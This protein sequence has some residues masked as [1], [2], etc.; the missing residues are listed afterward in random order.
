MICLLI[1]ETVAGRATGI[2]WNAAWVILIE[3]LKWSAQSNLGL[4][5]E[6]VMAEYLGWNLS[7]FSSA[8]L[9]MKSKPKPQSYSWIKPVTLLWGTALQTRLIS[10]AHT[11]QTHGQGQWQREAKSVLHSGPNRKKHDE[12]NIELWL[13]LAG[14]VFMA[15]WTQALWAVLTICTILQGKHFS[16]CPDEQSPQINSHNISLPTHPNLLQFFTIS[17]SFIPSRMLSTSWYSL[18]LH[19]YLR[20]H[21]YFHVK[22]C[23]SQKLRNCPKWTKGS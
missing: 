15:E 8:R 7:G 20:I 5:L 22:S 14:P 23:F 18:H 10:V 12:K 19:L 9:T 16:M 3:L 17:P 13:E 11:K 1:T 21:S 2:N 4:G 6:S